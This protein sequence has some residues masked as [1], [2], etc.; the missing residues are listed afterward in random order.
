MGQVKALPLAGTLDSV[1]PA[2][3]FDLV[4]VEAEATD[5]F[6]FD[7]AGLGDRGVVKSPWTADQTFALLSR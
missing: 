1:F 7:A 6:G 3:V 5:G 2:E 4:A